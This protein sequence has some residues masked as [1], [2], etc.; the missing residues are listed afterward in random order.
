MQPSRPDLQVAPTASLTSY[1]SASTGGAARLVVVLGDASEAAWLANRTLELAHEQNLSMLLVG[2]ALDPSDAAQMRR[3]LI[4]IAAFIQQEQARRVLGRIA[5]LARNPPGIEI[6]S[7]KD[8]CEEIGSAVHPG[9]VIA[10]DSR[11][12]IGMRGGPLNDLLAC[13]LRVPIYVFDGPQSPPSP[14]G[15]MLSGA[16]AWVGSVASLVGFLFLQVLIVTQVQGWAQ[17]LVLCLTVGAEV[18][19][20][21]FLNSALGAV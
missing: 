13:N 10:C 15:H 9:D 6:V 16:V 4:T 2:V 21:W 7:G 19:W 20:I 17:T 3:Q 1:A 12:A 14:R 5:C 11:Q 8:W 18:A